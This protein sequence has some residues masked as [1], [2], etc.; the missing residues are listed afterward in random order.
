[1]W[2]SGDRK[3]KEIGRK[4]GDTLPISPSEIGGHLTYFSLSLRTFEAPYGTFFAELFLLMTGVAI[5]Y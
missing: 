3:S 1:V 5:D 4:S 2:K